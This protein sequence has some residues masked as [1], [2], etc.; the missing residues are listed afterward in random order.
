MGSFQAVPTL[1][2]IRRIFKAAVA[3]PQRIVVLPLTRLPHHVDEHFSGLS[4]VTHLPKEGDAR[5]LHAILRL[6]PQVKAKAIDRSQPG[7]LRLNGSG[8]CRF[9]A[10]GKNTDRSHQPCG[11]HPVA[12]R[13]LRS[14]RASSA[15]APERPIE[16]PMSY[17]VLRN[18]VASGGWGFD[19]RHTT[20]VGPG[21]CY[22]ITKLYNQQFRGAY[23]SSV[24]ALSARRLRAGLGCRTVPAI[25][26]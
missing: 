17:T 20:L 6:Q 9:G 21:V 25:L 16:S 24:S 3:T 5:S 2:R 8:H 15:R 4:R 13:Q 23:A 11:Q 22:V 1:H 14:C 10:R 19:F 7:V 12:D 18:A 26:G